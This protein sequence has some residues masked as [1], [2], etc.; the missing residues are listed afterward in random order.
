MDNDFEV[1]KDDD[2]DAQK[3]ISMTLLL[4]SWERELPETLE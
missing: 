4:W 3:Y 1:V 2:E